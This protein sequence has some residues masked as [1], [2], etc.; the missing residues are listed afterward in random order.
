M[1]EDE[2][3]KLSETKFWESMSPRDIAAFQLNED[4]LCMPFGI[5]HDAVEK[6]LG[7]SVYTHEFAFNRSGLIAELGGECA[8]PSLEDI[9]A[10]FPESKRV[11]VIC[12]EHDSAE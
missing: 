10:M 9:L 5:F 11:V 1:N 12:P 6:T 7:R 2:A 8:A 4:R 3:I